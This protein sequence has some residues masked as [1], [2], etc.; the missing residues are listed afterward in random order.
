[1]IQNV[2]SYQLLLYDGGNVMAVISHNL[3][4]Q[5]TSH[6]LNITTKKKSKTSEK[7]ASGY[8]INRTADDAAGLQI[9][10]KMRGQIRGLNQ[11]S[12][13]I[14]DGISLCQVADGALNETHSLLQRIRELTVQ[15]ANDTNETVD[16]DAISQELNQLTN[17][18]DRIAETTS[19]NGGIYP[20]NAETG[21]IQGSGQVTTS[22]VQY[23]LPADIYESTCQV[24][25]CGEKGG[26]AVID[27]VLYH[28]GE[29]TTMTGLCHK[30]DLDSWCFQ[31]DA[32][33][34]PTGSLW[35]VRK[36]SVD[37]YASLRLSDLKIDDEGYVY[38]I[39]TIDGAPKYL[40]EGVCYD[41]AK[42]N[43]FTLYSKNDYLDPALRTKFVKGIKIEN[44]NNVQLR[45]TFVNSGV[46]IQAGASA[47]QGIQLDLVNAT[48]RGIGLKTP[49]DVSS[50]DDAGA[51]MV[52]IDEAIEAVSNYRSNFGAQQNRLEHAMIVD[53]N[54]AE[55][56]Q[57]AEMRIRDTDVAEEMLDYSKNNILEQVGQ[58][59]LAQANQSKQEILS[60]LQ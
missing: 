25:V 29:I 52:N 22:Q 36:D 54:T 20:L 39:S 23:K 33:I 30:E 59:M 57:Y 9:S 28:T 53:D 60:L 15:A 8:K 1:M 55:N 3:V 6:Q 19:F 43:Y 14:Q 58:S 26:A 47:N 41:P 12:R 32:N 18:V 13:N 34:L 56:I 10:E 50:F 7:L 49:V 2:A 24:E 31:G 11:A 40:A 51:A 42:L 16:R 38:Y 48:C 35:T 46:W 17:E 4:A 45:N 37:T 21:T 27:G 44:D 5:F